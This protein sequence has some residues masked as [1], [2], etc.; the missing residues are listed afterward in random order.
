M[1][2]AYVCFFVF[3]F[4]CSQAIKS[5]GFVNPASHWFMLHSAANA[6]ITL[7][8]AP[9][10]INT[11]SEPHWAVYRPAGERSLDW[12]NAAMLGSIHLYHMLFFKCTAA[13][14]FHHLLFVPFNQLAYFWPHLF[15]TDGRLWGSAINMQQFFVC[16]LPGGIDYFMLA[17]VKEGKM[18]RLRHKMWQAKINVW[19]RAPGLISCVTIVLFDSMRQ[20]EGLPTSAHVIALVDFLLIGFNGLYYMERVVESTGKNKALA[21][22]K[23]APTLIDRD[24]WLAPLRVS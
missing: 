7:V 22:G 20:W 2:Q 3:L 10:L 1:V 16:G 15:W 8:T 12:T 21:K 4:I 11:F 19:L 5:L 23:E 17:M 13:D 9:D 6:Y 14:W 24:N 18:D